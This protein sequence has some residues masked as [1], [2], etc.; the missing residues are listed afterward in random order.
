MFGKTG[1]AMRRYVQ[2]LA[3]LMSIYIACLYL[4]VSQFRHH[5]P[6]GFVAYVLAIAPALPIVG[7]FWAVMRLIIEETDEYVRMLYVRQALFGTGFCL[8]IVTTWDFLQNFGL[9]A[10][11]DNGFGA[12]FV[13]FV[14]FGL[15]DLYN[16]LTLGS[17]RCA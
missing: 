6:S 7:M 5:H 10:K 3:V 15:G 4:A 2:R 12:A 14:G 1:S 16:R 9:V 8:S 13:W 11:G 17:G